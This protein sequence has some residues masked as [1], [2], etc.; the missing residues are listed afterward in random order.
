MATYI[1]R[2]IQ[3]YIDGRG[4]GKEINEDRSRNTDSYRDR[5][6]VRA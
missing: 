6:T 5:D 3:R 4:R 1:Y 2:D